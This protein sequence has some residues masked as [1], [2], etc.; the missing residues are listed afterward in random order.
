MMITKKTYNSLYYVLLFFITFN[1]NTI[2]AGLCMNLLEIKVEDRSYK[3]PYCSNVKLS[4]INYLKSAIIV[5][6]GTNRNADDYYKYIKASV[7]KGHD[8][9]TVIIAPH[10]PTESDIE[11]YGL[12]SDV[13][14]WSSSGWKQGNK[15][16][17][18]GRIS[19]FAALEQV[20]LQL[21]TVSPNLRRIV[22]TGHSAGGQFVNRFIAGNSI[23]NELP[24]IAF[25]YAPVNPSSYLYFSQ[26]RVVQGTASTFVT[27]LAMD[28][29]TYDEYKYGMQ[30]LS[31]TG[32]M[33]S[34]GSD[35]LTRRY[36]TRNVTYILGEKDTEPSSSFDDSCEAM[37]QGENRLERGNIYYN[38]L[39]FM[40]GSAIY[41]THQKV[42]V[43]G[44]GH[45]AKRMYQSEVL[46]KYLLR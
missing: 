46:R 24:H 13:L 43:P 12:P 14:Y 10:F 39:G 21:A 19:S 25:D 5:I 18:D 2:F 33:A 4:N 32:Y 37:Y 1:I 27:P 9:S 30:N 28:C 31:Q 38:Y 26:H 3:L 22:I 15:S 40:Y 16:Q 35:E 6:H 20:I 42:I 44:V 23:E 36:A 7:G 29:P 11:A 17:G 45:D 8:D 34:V 41:R